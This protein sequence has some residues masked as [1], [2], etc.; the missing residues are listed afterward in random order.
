MIEPKF[1]K[2]DIVELVG[3][4]RSDKLKNNVPIKGVIVEHLTDHNQLSIGGSF[5]CYVI[6]GLGTY[7][8]GAL[9]LSL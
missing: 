7:G 4:Y 3:V 5:N 9:K 1:K 6:E 2:G 8:E